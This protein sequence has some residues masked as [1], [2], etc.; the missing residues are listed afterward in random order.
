MPEPTTISDTVAPRRAGS[1]IA[2][3]GKALHDAPLGILMLDARFPRGPGDMG[4]ATTRPFPA[5]YHVVAGAMPERVV[6]GGAMGLLPKFIAGAKQL[7]QLGADAI[8]TTCK[9]SSLFQAGIGTAVGVPVAM[10]SLPQVPSV[11]ATLPP[12]QRAGLGT[13]CGETLPEA[14]L[15]AVGVTPDTPVVGSEVGREILR[16]L[17]ENEQDPDVELAERDVLEAAITLV[18]RQPGVGAIVLEC[19]DT[20]PCAAAMASAVRRLVY[21]ICPMILWFQAGL[22]PRAFS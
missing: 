3:G 19:T 20:P 7:V 2:R 14:H 18:T 8:V 12:G 13:V 1:V 5:P 4:N 21:D 9:F 16:V 15:S 6:L 22:Q 11:Q 17:I 10:S